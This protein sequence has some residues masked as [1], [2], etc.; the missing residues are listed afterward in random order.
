MRKQKEFTPLEIKASNVAG[1]R[2][3]TG[4][5]L[6]ELLMV[7]GIIALLMAIMIPSLNKAKEQ[8]KNMVCTGNLRQYGIA[9]RMYL[10]DNDGVFLYPHQF[11]FDETP[12]DCQWCEIGIWKELKKDNKMGVLWPY[13]KDEALH[14]CPTFKAVAK[15][16]GQQICP[17]ADDPQYGYSMN[18]YLGPISSN[19]DKPWDKDGI[20]RETEVVRPSRTFFFSEENMW[21]INGL[22][23]AVLNDTALRIGE[24]GTVGTCDWFATFHNPPKAGINV[25]SQ[26]YGTGGLTKGSANAVFVDGHVDFIS[27]GIGSYST[28][29]E[30]LEAGCKIAHPKG[31]KP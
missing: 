14:L 24:T 21:K 28:M 5:T 8:A 15:Y 4:F 10:D 30:I 12:T 9:G 20:W 19:N 16:A 3:L 18:I 2:F 22:N 13:F 17:D 26:G 23:E 11:L 29:D 1:K 27:L 7:I 6:I 25:D 31:Y